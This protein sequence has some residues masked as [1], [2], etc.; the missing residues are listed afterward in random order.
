MKAFEVL[1]REHGEVCDVDDPHPKG[2]QVTVDVGLVGICGTDLGL[3]AADDERLR[4][5]RNH[6]PLRL[7]HEWSGIVTALGDGVDPRW[8]GI[9]VAGETMLGC[10]LCE[11]CRAAMPNLCPDRFEIGV[12][13]DWPGALAERL[14]VPASALHALPDSIDL[15]CGA[16]VEPA[17][18]AYRAVAASGAVDGSRILVLGSGTIGL[19]CLQ[20]AV[21]AG[22]EV[23]VL[24]I[25]PSSLALAAE[26]GATGV[27]RADDLPQLRWDAVI[28]ATDAPALPSLALD[29]V[30]P[31]CRVVLIGVAHRPSEVDSRRIVRK[32][33]S[34]FGI[35]GASQGFGLAIAAYASGAVD[36]RPLIGAVVGLGA[37]EE[38]LQGHRPPGAGPGPKLLIDPRL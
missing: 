38:A 35:L 4:E 24:G 17:G 33:L 2:G 28:D 25:D 23:H 30:T 34:V 20:F 3:F 22:G 37:V 36:P 5:T 27:W 7:G 32:E 16:L 10:G 11:F 8:L 1:R 14:V 13:G 29:L 21:A 19:L 12:R 31:G 18:S 15:Q 26:L 9:R 6:Y